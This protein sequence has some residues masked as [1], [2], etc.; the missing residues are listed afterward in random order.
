MAIVSRKLLWLPDPDVDYLDHV[1]GV[2]LLT[3]HLA[4]LKVNGLKQFR[5][6]QRVILRT[7]CEMNL[8]MFP[9]DK[10]VAVIISTHIKYVISF[11]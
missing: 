2:E 3:G 7:T 8:G 1:G 11:N 10:Q 9:H 6:S 4:S 5:L